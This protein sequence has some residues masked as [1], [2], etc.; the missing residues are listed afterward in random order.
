MGGFAVGFCWEEAFDSAIEF[1][2][3]ELDQ[4][5]IAFVS[6]QKVLLD[7]FLALAVVGVVVPA[8]K[9][10]V[11]P[12]IHEEGYKL[13]ISQRRLRKYLNELLSDEKSR[14]QAVQLFSS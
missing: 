9:T 14:E 11:T 8:W 4:S 6:G 13:G 1:V 10:H 2:S 5:S 7:A 12:M 3:E